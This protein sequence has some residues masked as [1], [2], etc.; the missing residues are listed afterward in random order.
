[1]PN[2]PVSNI[3]FIHCRSKHANGTIKPTGGL[4]I[5]YNL[6]AQFKVVGYAAAKCHEKDLYNKQIGRMKSSGR[7]LSE[8][9]YQDTPEVDEA[10]FIQQT[11]DDY[12]KAFN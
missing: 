4:T 12:A 8:K 11:K 1:M 9:Y 5:A 10:T 2:R 6:N 7:L 3:K